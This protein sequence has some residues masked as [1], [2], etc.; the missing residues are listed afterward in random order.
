MAK[1]EYTVEL[2]TLY[3]VEVD[4]W[5]DWDIQRADTIFTTDSKRDAYA[6]LTC[7]CHNQE[8]HCNRLAYNERVSVTLVAWPEIG[9]GEVVEY[10]E[11]DHDGL[12]R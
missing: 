8:F 5:V 6:V 9:Y 2:H 11:Y 3:R 10:V 1:V 4:G 12:V 7:V